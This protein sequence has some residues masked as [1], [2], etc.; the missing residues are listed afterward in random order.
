[1]SENLRK[2]SSDFGKKKNVRKTGTFTK[3]VPAQIT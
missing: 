2:E 3:N 1:M